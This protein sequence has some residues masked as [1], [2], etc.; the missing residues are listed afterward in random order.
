MTTSTTTNAPTI[1]PKAS[2]EAVLSV[3]DNVPP[4]LKGVEKHTNAL[5]EIAKEYVIDSP[6]MFE[7]AAADL[8]AWRNE[9]A[10]LEKQRTYLKAP[11]LEGGRRVDQLYNIPKNALE[12][13]AKILAD[14][15]G[16][17][18]AEQDRIIEDARRA[19]EARRRKEQ[20]ELEARQREAQE[21]ADKARR[22]AAAAADE[23]EQAARD[24]RAAGDEEAAAAAEQAAAEAQEEANARA[25][26]AAN[27]AAQAQLAIDVAAVAPAPAYTSP[28]LSAAGVNSRTTWGVQ[29][30]DKRALIIG[31]A[32]AIESNDPRA[33]ELMSYLEENTK[34]LN[35]VGKQLKGAARVPGVVFG[36]KT[37]IVRGR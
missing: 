17:Y 37:S 31:V 4:E 16:V 22:E 33:E 23:A 10:D 11:F 28:T 21:Q 8:V 34:V 32:K 9:A 30:I 29:S 5:V 25:S 19:E 7:A 36:P 2:T 13:A 14:K 3:L 6:L 26:A 27:E 35:G 18:K 20:Q 24:A 1:A 12:S 15:M